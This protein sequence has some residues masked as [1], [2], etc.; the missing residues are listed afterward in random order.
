MPALLR[1]RVEHVSSGLAAA[2]PEAVQR[3]TRLLWWQER[4]LGYIQA[5]EQIQGSI[6]HTMATVNLAAA[7]LQE[8]QELAQQC[9]Q[10]LQ[11]IARQRQQLLADGQQERAQRLT[12]PCDPIRSPRQLAQV[13]TCLEHLR[14]SLPH[15]GITNPDSV[16]QEVRR[17]QLSLL[18]CS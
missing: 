1:N 14:V 13:N 16:N 18:V 7:G 6:E 12:D 11:I 9:E 5:L 4:L 3:P 10:L 8:L 15:L 17:A 2:T